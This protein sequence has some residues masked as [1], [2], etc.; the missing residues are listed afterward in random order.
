MATNIKKVA[1]LAEA[2]S[3]RIVPAD[4]NG[5]GEATEINCRDLLRISLTVN[6]RQI[7]TAAGYSVTKSACS[8][9]YASAAAAV[10]LALGKP[11]L[12]AYA[13]SLE[14]IGALLSDDGE[15]D[16]AH[17]HCA[18]MAELALKRAVVNYS[19]RRGTGVL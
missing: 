2:G 11:A 8:A 14:D 13:V 6:Q 18:L 9:L 15:L 3:Y 16:K 19:S 10:S 12:A 1:Q 4:A 5:C 17:I 7:V